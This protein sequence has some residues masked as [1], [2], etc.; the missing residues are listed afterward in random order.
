M[1]FIVP[2][3]ANVI[4]NLVFGG[5]L[6][7]LSVKTRIN[8]DYKCSQTPYKQTLAKTNVSLMFDKR[9]NVEIKLRT[10]AK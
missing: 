2:K 5:V 3:Y 4:C 8:S 10:K 6:T 7:D 1:V 9:Y